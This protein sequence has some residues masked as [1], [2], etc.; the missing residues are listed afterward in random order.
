MSGNNYYIFSKSRCGDT[1]PSIITLSGETKPL[2]SMIDPKREAQRLVSTITEDTGFVV[3]FGI[4]GGFAPNAALEH[5]KA[6]VIVIDFNKDGIEELFSNIDYSLLRANDRFKFLIDPSKEDLITLILE[7]YKP[8]L[9][10]GIKTIPLRTRTEQDREKFE[11]AAVILQEAID[12]VSSDYSVQAH[13]G[14][15]WFSNIIRNVKASDK[16][17]SSLLE[18]YKSGNITDTAI[19]AAGPSLDSQIHKLKEFKSNNGFII[20]T[21]TALGALLHNNITPDA[22]LSIDCQHISLYHFMCGNILKNRDIPLIMD[23]ASPP[24]LANFSKNYAFFSSGHPLALYLRK[25]WRPL[26]LLDTSGGNVTYACLSLAENIG[27]KRITLFGADFSYVGCRSYARGTYIYRYFYE[28]QNR[29]SSLEKQFSA[30]LYRSPFLKNEN[31][32]KK[33]YSETSSL[34]FYRKKLEDKSSSMDAEINFATGFGA[35]VNIKKNSQKSVSNCQFTAQI[36]NNKTVNMS[37]SEF[38]EQYRN[39]ILALPEAD[40]KE[41]YSLYLNDKD[42]EIFTTLL[43]SAAAIKKRNSNLRHNDLIE[44]VKRYC[45]GE[46]DKLL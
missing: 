5:T 20:S 45:A 18:D 34:R 3:F 31:D 28:R 40:G 22:V 19:A 8:A 26:S 37:G 33:N 11:L 6:Q 44:E 41:N 10:G 16:H 21:D 29:L 39:D 14:K 36:N 1:V 30:F 35:P 7:N 4:G 12:T 25:Y 27:S 9:H 23:I 2:H 24:L 42:R 43:P 13:F 32:E 46:I 17:G 15:R 38:L